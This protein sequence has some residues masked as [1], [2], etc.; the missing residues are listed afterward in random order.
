MHLWL[1]AEQRD[2]E[3]RVGLTPQG[4]EQL[5]AQG[6]RVTVERSEARAIPDAAY[7]AT[8]CEMAPAHSWPNA[9]ADAIVLGL[10]ELDPHG[11]DLVHRH[12]MFG[13]AYKGQADGPALLSRF[14]RGGGR[15]LDLEY[16]TNVD[17]R[18]VAA[19]G[20]WAGFAGAA[21]GV[22]AWAA[23]ASSQVLGAIGTYPGR[24]ALVA[25]VSAKMKE[26]VADATKSPLVIVIGAKGR[27]GTGA[28]D[29]AQALGLEVTAWDMAQTAHGG[30]FPEIL[31]HE[32]F[33][34]CILASPGVPVFV[35][36]GAVEAKRRLGVIA[37]VS[38]DPSSDYNPIPVYDRATSFDA[39]LV[40]VGGA[41][42]PL[43]VMAIDNLPSLLPV[44]SSQDYGGQLLP[45]LAALGDDPDGVWQ[46]ASE[47][48]D[49]HVARL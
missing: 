27:V 5:L 41:S 15:L 14:K 12:I 42:A 6:F 33:V 40:Q 8:G 3:R 23:Q 17:G 11:P 44:E 10:K 26:A 2:F 43:D 16:L 28:C 7:L 25:D 29:L 9:P 39:P 47:I 1:R 13:H 4:V 36:T 45:H 38:C 22:M 37:D 48:F 49:M 19:F 31:E 21:L 24:E 18:R 46:R 34:N 35:P 32:I 20:Y 30:P